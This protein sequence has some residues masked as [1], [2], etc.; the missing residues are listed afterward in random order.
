M[1]RLHF[2]DA[3]GRIAV[4]FHACINFGSRSVLND[5]R[6]GCKRLGRVLGYGML[7]NSDPFD[8]ECLPIVTLSRADTN[9]E[10]GR[11]LARNVMEYAADAAPY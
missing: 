6:C 2:R 9:R 5:F 11:C 10:T 4:N 7:D 1:I 8:G 3:H